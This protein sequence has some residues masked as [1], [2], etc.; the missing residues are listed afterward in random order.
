MIKAEL[1][2]RTGDYTYVL[3]TSATR[4]TTSPQATCIPNGKQVSATRISTS[5]Q[6]MC[7]L[8]KRPQRT[9]NVRIVLR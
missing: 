3:S 5:P 2:V 8:G 1:P 6:A 4:I 7:I 9:D